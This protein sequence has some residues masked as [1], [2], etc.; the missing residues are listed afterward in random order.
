MGVGGREHDHRHGVIDQRDRAMLEFSGRVAFG[1]NIGQ[2]LELERTFHRQREGG[3]AAKVKNA[4]ARATSRA[5]GSIFASFCITA[6]IWPGAADQF[7]D[8]VA[9]LL[10]AQHAAGAASA[11]SETGE[12]ASWQ[13]KALVEATPISGPARVR[14]TTSLSLAMVEVSTLTIERIL[15]TLDLA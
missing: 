14:A 5:T 2:L 4:A 13:V 7:G 6:A 12:D 10:E 15:L 1:V 8:E 3:A 11:R 9:L